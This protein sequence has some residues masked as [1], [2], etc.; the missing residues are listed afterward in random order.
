MDVELVGEAVVVVAL[1]DADVWVGVVPLR[2]PTPF[3][4]RMV[5]LLV[6][7]S[8][9]ACAREI[10]LCDYPGYQPRLCT[11][12]HDLYW[13]SVQKV[14]YPKVWKEVSFTSH[15]REALTKS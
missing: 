5:M 7:L 12:K 14:K 2:T 13:K 9:F 1:T 8:R 15:G 6:V 11:V 10:W 3:G 4:P